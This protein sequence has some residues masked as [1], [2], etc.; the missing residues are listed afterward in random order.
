MLQPSDDKELVFCLESKIRHSTIHVEHLCNRAM[1][2]LESK[3]RHSTIQL[4]GPG[5]MGLFCLE[6]KIRHSTIQKE[7]HLTP[8]GFALNPK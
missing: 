4:A 8:P 7:N 3:I 6:S 5:I 1:F 2:C